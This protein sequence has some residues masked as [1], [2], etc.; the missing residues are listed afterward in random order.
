[1]DDQ[2]HGVVNALVDEKKRGVPARAYQV[3]LSALDDLVCHCRQKYMSLMP[4][5]P[6]MWKFLR[7]GILWGLVW[8]LVFIA[9]DMVH[10]H[11]M[12]GTH[13]EAMKVVAVMSLVFAA[14]GAG[15]GLGL[16]V[17]AAIYR[18]LASD[19]SLS[20]AAAPSLATAILIPGIY[21]AVG[22]GIYFWKFRT[23]GGA[24]WYQRAAL[25]AIAVTIVGVLTAAVF[26]WLTKSKTRSERERILTVAAC[27]IAVVAA[28][29][30]VMRF[31][32]P[33]RRGQTAQAL[34]RIASDGREKRK[35]IVIAIDGGTWHVISPLMAKGRLP[36]F[37]SIIRN[38][39]HGDVK[40]LWPPYWSIAAWGA[41]T[42]GH[43]REDVGVFG[44]IQ[45]RI[46]G[47]PAFQSPMD[48]EPKLLNITTIEYL[49]ASRRMIRAEVPDRRS[50][51]VPPVWEMLDRS[52]IETAVVRFNF[53]Y[54]ATGQAKIVVSNL[55]LADVW[56]LLGVDVPDKS[57]LVEPASRRDELLAEFSREKKADSV[58][59]AKVF[60]LGKWPKPQDAT[61][62]P[63]GGLRGALHF[64]FATFATASHLLET[65]PEI[66]VLFVHI[67]G[68][69]TIEHMFWQY[70]F[71]G[72]FKH[73]P[74]QKDVAALGEVIDRY[75][76][77]VD[78]GIA[79][80]IG[81]FSETPNVLIVSDHGQ[82]AREDG[83]PFK[84]WHASPG[85]FLAAGPDIAPRAG[86]LDVSYYDIV[87]KILDLKGLRKPAELRGQS[88]LRDARTCCQQ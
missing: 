21:V 55:A 52:G 23:I 14:L 45:V 34:E 75:M 49:L 48:L 41:I 60:P 44:D 64:D 42:T 26:L 76:E 51:K 6:I 8:G 27:S 46:P 54:P 12:V 66:E 35:L 22:A 58:D 50:L 3:I 31:P 15:I 33:G 43:P 4:L 29:V 71:P 9:P 30:F 53:S 68:V 69:D 83:V 79:K 7:D 24:G 5:L 10:T 67:G 81:S 18:R 40:A 88:L 80:M 61:L 86:L 72:E 2:L 65:D 73:K 17:L 74:A 82:A 1:M 25:L 78:R 84:G 39:V 87:P 70:R 38:G 56:G 57:G 11:Y 63:V 16:F 36:T 77:F 13:A 28:V 37:A 62:N 20:R 47:L 32:S 19:A 85:I 59:L